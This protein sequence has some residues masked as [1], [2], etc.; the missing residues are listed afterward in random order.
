MSLESTIAKKIAE[1]DPLVDSGNPW[2]SYISEI[3]NSGRPPHPLGT[4]VPEEIE[5]KARERLKHQRGQLFFWKRIK[6]Y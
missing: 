3:Y 2:S 5:E 1:A 6:T 4:V